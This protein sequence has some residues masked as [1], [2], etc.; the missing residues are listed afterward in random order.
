MGRRQRWGNLSP[1]ERTGRAAETLRRLLARHER[2]NH[3]WVERALHHVA[4][5]AID[6]LR[7]HLTADGRG[8]WRRPY[9]QIRWPV[10]WDW[11]KS[12]VVTGRFDSE[13]LASEEGLRG[14]VA[15]IAV[16]H[17]SVTA[18]WAATD[19][20]YVR[21]ED[22]RG[23]LH[24]PEWLHAE[25]SKLR[26][27]ERISA[28]ESLHAPYALGAI[29]SSMDHDRLAR[30][31]AEIAGGTGWDE[32]DTYA[33]EQFLDHGALG[34]TARPGITF[35]APGVGCS[36]TIVLAVEPL[37]LDVDAREAYFPVTVGIVFDPVEGP[38]GTSFPDPASW[39]DEQRARLW[40]DVDALGAFKPISR[41]APRRLVRLRESIQDAF[42]GGIGIVAQN[43]QL[44]AVVQALWAGGLAAPTRSRGWH[45]SED[46]RLVFVCRV[47]K[48][49]G[50]VVVGLGPVAGQTSTEDLWREVS[51]L[52]AFAA[53]VALAVL[54]QVCKPALGDEPEGL[55]GASVRISARQILGYIGAGGR[56]RKR[57]EAARRVAAAMER[58][59]A[60]VC[61]VSIRSKHRGEAYRWSGEALFRIVRADAGDDPDSAAWD[62]RLGQWTELWLNRSAS[63]WTARMAKSLLRLPR[64]G[65]RASKLLAKKIGINL[66][67]EP[68]KGRERRVKHRTLLA[69]AGE[70]PRP[71]H[72]NEHTYGR[73]RDRLNGALELLCHLGILE[74]C[75]PDCR[76]GA[77]PENRAKGFSG[78]WLNTTVTLRL[79]APYYSERRGTRPG[80]RGATASADGPEG[81]DDAG[82][83][84]SSGVWTEVRVRRHELG[85]KLIEVAGKIG[86][87][88]PYLSRLERG[89]ARGST[90]LAARGTAWLN[91]VKG[92]RRP[93]FPKH[94]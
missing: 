60:L 68:Y 12:H 88:A 66:L 54:A 82:A 17:V 10:E 35:N 63:L 87:G 90:G 73:L 65:N 4:A 38:D 37:T 32:R 42:P 67:L 46:G 53:D 28:I 29:P 86:I 48:L 58:L 49:R 36:G 52:D 24:V 15:S 22:G 47:R 19:W 9:V 83:R 55:A 20:T 21:V 91:A 94:P 14:A 85:M 78:P 5:V 31:V 93:L 74:S 50:S 13:S 30:G 51:N 75:A 80:S 71:E 8:S 59:G 41:A 6:H 11:E 1:A 81:P 25:L 2:A 44:R 92:R 57:N 70:L 62:V 79:A 77:E 34:S 45:L 64:S 26:G 33:L 43:P 27:R 76:A 84:P 69:D 40:Q 39:S 89:A 61:D 72:L 56:G 16:E 3:D 23:I 18:M 7:S